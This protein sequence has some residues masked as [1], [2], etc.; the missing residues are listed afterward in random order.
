MGWHIDSGVLPIA[1]E[2]EIMMKRLTIVLVALVLLSVACVA[3]A[4]NLQEGWYAAFG[5]AS[6]WYETDIRYEES[7]GFPIA[8]G[9]YGPF[10]VESYPYWPFRR[11]KVPQS[12]QDVLPGTG[13]STI[14]SLKQYRPIVMI[15]FEYRT[16]YDPDMMRLELVVMDADQNVESV[17]WSQDEPGYKSGVWETPAWNS[18]GWVP[19]DKWLGVRVVAV[20]EPAC[21]LGLLIPSVAFLA[22]W[23]R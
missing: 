14:Q 10:T 11:V 16:D 8:F 12:A 22:K 18:Y 3:S 5:G 21:W 4:A 23:R 6:V 20:P 7:V 9:D 19:A 13:I 15:R 17:L 1:L 2:E